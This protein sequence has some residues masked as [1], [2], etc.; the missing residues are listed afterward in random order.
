VHLDFAL[1]NGRAILF[2][3]V[4]GILER[5][6]PSFPNW[7]SIAGRDL[8]IEAIKDMR[9]SIDYLESRADI[10]DAAIAFYGYSW[11]GRI[12]PI[13]L[14]VEPKRLKVGI[15]NQAGLKHLSIPETSVL[16]YLPRVSAPILQFNGRYDTDFRFESSAKPFFD[17]L[18]T[19]PDLKKHIVNNTSH[20]V[21]R[22]IVI[23][24]TLDWL[25]EHLGPVN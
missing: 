18:G 25:D 6:R 19:S 14:A 10:N 5:R 11:G 20:Y 13:A 17:L 15:L 1:R 16:N 12:G 9:R 3:V 24:E 8:V 7:S 22:E 23:G 4:D 21:P 2:P